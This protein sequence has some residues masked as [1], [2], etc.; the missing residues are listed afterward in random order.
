MGSIKILQDQGN[1]A[2]TTG[3]SK[4][5]EHSETKSHLAV[6]NEVSRFSES[7]KS[8]YWNKLPPSL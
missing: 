2:S 3:H 1:N 8:F 4:A 6:P 5:A 7:V